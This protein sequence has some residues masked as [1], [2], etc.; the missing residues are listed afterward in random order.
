MRDIL[1]GNLWLAQQNSGT[2]DEIIDKIRK[3][4]LTA[5]AVRDWFSNFSG[6][7][8]YRL[9][10]KVFSNIDYRSAKRTLDNINTHLPQ[11]Q[12]KMAQLKKEHIILVG[13]DE[14][15]DSSNRFIYD[16]G[17]QWKVPES[18]TV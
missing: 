18:K 4:E 16:L 10:L 5:E 7:D 17:K 12:Q 1:S 6:E 15:M 14:P 3:Y 2:L 8:E 11:I 9:A 13:S